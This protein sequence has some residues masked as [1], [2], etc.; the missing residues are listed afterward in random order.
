MGMIQNQVDQ[1][2][3]L[4]V[5]VHG[6]RPIK[7]ARRLIEAGLGLLIDAGEITEDSRIVPDADMSGTFHFAKRR[8]ADVVTS[9]D[10]L[11]AAFGEMSINPKDCF[12]V[13]I[14]EDGDGDFSVDYLKTPW[15]LTTGEAT[16]AT[17]D[18]M[19]D[20]LRAAGETFH[21]YAQHH[22]DK[23][24]PDTEKAG[25]NVKMARK[26]F[27]AMGA[28]YSG[29]LRLH[30]NDGAASA[31]IPGEDIPENGSRAPERRRHPRAGC[32]A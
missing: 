29:L 14:G 1:I 21:E 19:I 7:V 8:N 27:E 11:E 28:P 17:E 32:R 26:C 23:D 12:L 22:M 18:R 2:T 13:V 6:R 9:M 30:G 3:D 16:L 24:L 4:L 15:R 10:H 25:R 31:M 5:N 20:V